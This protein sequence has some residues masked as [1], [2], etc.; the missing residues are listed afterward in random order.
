MTAPVGLAHDALAA[1]LAEDLWLVAQ[2]DQLLVQDAAGRCTRVEPV[3]AFP[4]SDPEHYLAL[5]DARGQEQALVADPQSLPEPVRQA[6][7]RLLAQREFLPRIERIVRIHDRR[8]PAVWEV[9]TDRGPVTFLVRDPEDI[10][11]LGPHQG[12]IVDVHGVRYLVR[13]SR[14]LDPRSQRML[15][16]YL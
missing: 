10:R 5:V 13:D 1:K 8:D 14:A 12:L 15:S 4:I 6:I 9:I 7:A 16:R 11:R 2:G 3:R